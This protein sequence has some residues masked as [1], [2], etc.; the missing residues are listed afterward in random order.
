MWPVGRWKSHPHTRPPYAR[1]RRD[2]FGDSFV[3]SS[4]VRTAAAQSSVK[5]QLTRA[6]V[7][8]RGQATFIEGL[9]LAYWPCVPNTRRDMN[10]DS[11]RKRK[12]HNLT[13]HPFLSPYSIQMTR[14]LFASKFIGQVSL[15]STEKTCLAGDN[16][17]ILSYAYGAKRNADKAEED[18]RTRHSTQCDLVL[19]WVVRFLILGR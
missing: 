16:S 10:M 2:A 19:L 8:Q 1:P 12:K 15:Q 6:K 13:L 14:R 9:L 4:G 18:D 5:E 11:Y 7:P 17:W 3:L